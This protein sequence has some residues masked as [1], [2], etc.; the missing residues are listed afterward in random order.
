MLT[1][2]KDQMEAFGEEMLR[3]YKQRMS[4]HLRRHFPQQTEALDDAALARF[5]DEGIEQA[6]RYEI[7]EETTVEKF[8][9]LLMR[10]GADFDTREEFAWAKKILRDGRLLSFEKL[11]RIEEYEKLSH[12]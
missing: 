5:I 2:R 3:Q 6:A 8:L 11:E 10:H 1:I 9:E 7:Q 4:V 12:S